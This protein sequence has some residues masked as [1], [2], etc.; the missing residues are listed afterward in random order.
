MQL[1]LGLGSAADDVGT[2]ATGRLEQL[3][4]RA[5]PLDTSDARGVAHRR[6][7][8][9]RAG[10][11]DVVVDLDV[12]ATAHDRA[13]VRSDGHVAG[14][15]SSS[16]AARRT[17]DAERPRPPS[18]L[19]VADVARWWPT[20]YGDQPLLPARRRGEATTSA[21]TTGRA[22]RSASEPFA[23]TP[24]ERPDGRTFAIHVNGERIWVRGV[25]WIPADC[26]PSRNTRRHSSPACSARRRQANA[27]L[28]RVWGGG[29][30]ESDEFYDDCDRRGLLVWQDFAFA[31]A[32][33]PE[34]L[35]HDEVAAEAV[36]NVTRLLS[37]PS[38]AL[39]CGNNECLEGWS[40]WGWPAARRRSPVGR[41]VLPP[42]APA[43]RRRARP[44]P[45]VHR[46]LA[47]PSL[48]PAIT[49][50]DADHGTVHLWDVW[51]HLDYEHYRTHRPRFVAEFGFQAPPTAATLAAAVTDAAAHALM[52]P[53]C[54]ITRRPI[55]G[56]AKLRRSLAHHFGDVDDFD[57]WLYLTQVNQ[58]RADRRR[59]RPPPRPCTSA[60]RASCGGSSTTAGRRSAGRSSTAPGGASRAGTRCG[61]RSP[62][63]CSC[64]SRDSTTAASTSTSTSSWSTMPP[65]PGTPP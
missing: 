4:R 54:S 44:R 1:R 16:P 8:R 62:T 33:Y 36:D 46:R 11:V 63:V 52:P 42:P 20:G 5:D 19:D 26:F 41:R 35:L 37:H 25:N 34:A 7:R 38:L 2:V 3:G 21:A 32:A 9:R 10:R 59:R 53:S 18:T 22:R 47:R 55:D 58:A 23:S 40:D 6:A 17:P 24:S 50:N 12:D 14:R 29:V 61:G 57:D 49:P 60:A 48:D 39:W 13:T 45:A 64:S 65:R 27:N 15:R 43:T 31:C 28:V 56:E 51:N 30:Y